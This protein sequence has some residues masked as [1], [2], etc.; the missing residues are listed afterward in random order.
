M[1]KKF[2]LCLW[3]RLRLVSFVLE[4]FLLWYASNLIFYFSFHWRFSIDP[5]EVKKKLDTKRFFPM[6]WPT[7][8]QQHS[9]AHA[10]TRLDCIALFGYK[11]SFDSMDSQKNQFNSSA[12]RFLGWYWCCWCWCYVPI[13][14]ESYAG[15]SSS[16]RPLQPGCCICS[17]YYGML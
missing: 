16:T 6:N 17:R 5:Q 4:A 2:S 1:L 14:Y 15:N 12:E 8:L 7:A 3:L 9:Y 11:N 10:P 13:W